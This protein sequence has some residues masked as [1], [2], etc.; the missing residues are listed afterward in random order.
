M[1]HAQDAQSTFASSIIHLST[2][3]P[4]PNKKRGLKTFLITSHCFHFQDIDSTHLQS[5]EELD[6]TLTYSLFNR[7]WLDCCPC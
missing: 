5:V 4:H 6:L 7:L 1:A 2:S 3:P